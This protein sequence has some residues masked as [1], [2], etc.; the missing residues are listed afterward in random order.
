MIHHFIFFVLLVGIDSIPDNWAVKCEDHAIWV[1]LP[2][3]NTVVSS[4]LPAGVTL[5][6]NQIPQPFTRELPDGTHPV[7][8][9]L[10]YQQKCHWKYLPIIELYFHELK[11]EIPYVK[12]VKSGAPLM[13]KPIIYMDS[14]VNSD[15]SGLIYGL[16]SVI[17]QTMMFDTNKLVYNTS[18]LSGDFFLRQF[19]DKYAPGN[20][21]HVHPV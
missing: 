13:S 6:P 1:I 3:N 14:V 12:S 17:A 10:G 15:A 19:C 4:A 7:I 8:F 5:D 21:R 11:Y 16:P 18:T 20:H 2:V 9:E